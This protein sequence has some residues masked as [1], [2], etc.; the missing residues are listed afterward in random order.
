MELIDRH[1]LL[2]D[3]RPP[4]LGDVDPGEM[5]PFLRGLLFTDGTVTRTL[6][7]RALRRVQVTVIEQADLP[8][9]AREADGLRAAAGT[10]A[11][12]RR[13]AIGAEGAEP[14]VWAE[15]HILPGRL[16]AGFLGVLGG[17]R[18]GI[19]ESL[20]TVELESWREMLWLGLSEP[21]TWGPSAPAADSPA[22]T[23]CY[24]V[25]TAGSPA[26]LITECFAVERRDGAYRLRWPR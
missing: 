3:R 17:A 20:Q 7:V 22:I 19:G 8:L 1:F 5:D 6:E 10:D 14:A 21:P 16:P 24:R 18:D 4:D 12:R 2:N 15:S 25:I 11:V 13:V 9:G 23:R 26:L